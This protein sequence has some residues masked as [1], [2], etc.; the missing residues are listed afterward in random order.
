M[1]GTGGGRRLGKEPGEPEPTKQQNKGRRNPKAAQGS[2]P[3]LMGSLP[4]ANKASFDGGNRLALG[5]KNWVWA[6]RQNR[7]Q[8]SRKEGKGRSALGDTSEPLPPP[9]AQGV[10]LPP[11]HRLEGASLSRSSM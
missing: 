9:R 10:R 4:Q 8:L 3:A 6:P 7:L 11:S 2:R 1:E 5:A